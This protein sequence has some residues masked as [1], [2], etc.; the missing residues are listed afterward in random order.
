MVARQGASAVSFPHGL[1]P[2]ARDYLGAF[3]DARGLDFLTWDLTLDSARASFARR[4]A[5]RESD[6][7]LKVILVAFGSRFDI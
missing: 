3:A 2:F 7:R 6:P 5:R 1:Y 4:L